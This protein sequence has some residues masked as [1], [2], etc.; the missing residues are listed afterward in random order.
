MGQNNWRELC[1]QIM[2]ESNP[3]RLMDLVERLNQAL[4]SREEELRDTAHRN[5][6]KPGCGS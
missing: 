4:E 5:L 2:K 1:E 3:D 6:P